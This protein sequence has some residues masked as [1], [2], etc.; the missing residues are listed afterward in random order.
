MFER[1]QS[2]YYLLG[3]VGNGTVGSLLLNT[4]FDRTI[5]QDNED[6][7]RFGNETHI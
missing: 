6:N 7:I 2:A 3:R 4:G 1:I 5:R